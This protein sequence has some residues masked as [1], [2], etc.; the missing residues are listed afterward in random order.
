[1]VRKFCEQHWGNSSARKI[2]FQS[3]KRFGNF[4]IRRHAQRHKIIWSDSRRFCCAR[5]VSLNNTTGSFFHLLFA[6]ASEPET[7]AERTS[8][9]GSK[10][11]PKDSSS[12]C[13]II[14]KEGRLLSISPH[15]VILRQGLNNPASKAPVLQTLRLFQT[16]QTWPR[17]AIQTPPLNDFSNTKIPN[18]LAS[19]TRHHYWFERVGLLKR[20]SS[21][22]SIAQHMHDP[23]LCGA[24]QDVRCRVHARA[25]PVLAADTVGD[26]GVNALFG[27]FSLPNVPVQQGCKG[28]SWSTLEGWEIRKNSRGGFWHFSTRASTASRAKRG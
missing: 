19:N 7:Q 27:L 21:I 24:L 22:N 1:V 2:V 8:C 14:M 16:W 13:D 10:T 3:D 15:P 17:E 4:A 25:E 12:N 6:D 18:P 26:E 5:F 28:E 9:C 23:T 20:Q 11:G